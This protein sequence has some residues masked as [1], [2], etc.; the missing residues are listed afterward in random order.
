MT[1]HSVVD[2]AFPGDLYVMERGHGFG[3]AIVRLQHLLEVRPPEASRGDVAEEELALQRG[4]RLSA[5]DEAVGDGDQNIN[6]ASRDS[7]CRRD[8]RL[9]TG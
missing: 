6:A 7:A 2:L 5:V 3:V 4:D 1:G 8:A 9:R